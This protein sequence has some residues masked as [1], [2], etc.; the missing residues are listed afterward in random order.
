ML[1]VEIAGL[2]LKNPTVLAS[3]IL[4]TTAASLL[5]VARN[6]A[7]AVVAK[8]CGVTPREGHP[9]PTVVEIEQG[10][11]NAVG[12]ANPGVEE[13]TEELR[14][15]LRG[16]VPVI[17][18]V[19]GFRI[20]DYAE[21]AKIVSRA[22]VSAIE[23]NLSCPNVEKVGSLFGADAELAHE[24]VREVKRTVSLPVFAKL[25]ANVGDIVEIAKACEEGGADGITAINTLKA[26]AID[27]KAK[28]PV[29]GNKVGGLSGQCLKPVALR[30]VYEIAQEVEI[31]I[32]GCGGVTTGR[33]AVEYLMAG[34]RAV[35]IGSAVLT[36][37]ISVFKK[38]A[39]E[40]QEFLEERGYSHVRDIVGL[41]LK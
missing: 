2:E 6:G 13:F 1:D 32:M 12:L 34:A 36:R 16:G 28:A 35:Q 20:E 19:Y 40:I 39:L 17:A 33:D 37:G 26:M 10:I 3:G 8:S 15:A 5:R 25:T 31:P 9:N 27:I 24:V 30:C 11:L 23:L 14:Q 29:L 7:G 21:A 18:S 41:A 38:V 4:G 22:G